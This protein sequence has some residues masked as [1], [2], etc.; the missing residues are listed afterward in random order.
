M[1]T[2]ALNGY[3][4]PAGQKLNL[5]HLS[6]EDQEYFHIWLWPPYGI[7]QAIIFSCCGFYLFSLV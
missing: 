7:G 3:T 5:A 1:I 6:V 2:G 4:E